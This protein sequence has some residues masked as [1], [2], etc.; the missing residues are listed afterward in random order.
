MIPPGRGVRRRWPAI[1][2]T[3]LGWAAAMPMAQAGSLVVVTG[4]GSSFESLD[5]ERLA[6]IYRRKRLFWDRHTRAIP[7]N[8]PADDPLRMAFSQAVFGVPPEALLDYWN[9]QYF[10]GVAPPHVLQSQA[11]VKRFVRDTEGA[12]GYLPACATR[13]GLRVLLVLEVE[14]GAYTCPSSE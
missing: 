14:G 10:Q 2:L 13:E 3:L 9:R 5:R 12:L 8:L 1:L 7:V 6:Q 4:Q 11:A